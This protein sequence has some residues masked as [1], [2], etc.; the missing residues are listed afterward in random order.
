MSS[1]ENEDLEFENIDNFSLIENDENSGKKQGIDPPKRS[2]KTL[3]KKKKKKT[4]L[5]LPSL[6]GSIDL[7]SSIIQASQSFLQAWPTVRD[8]SVRLNFFLQPNLFFS[9][10]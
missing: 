6:A 8:L 5:S 1:P 9:N 10:Q 2:Q 7:G 4:S 3:Q